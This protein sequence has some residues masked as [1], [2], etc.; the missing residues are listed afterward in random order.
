MSKCSANAQ[1][2]AG[3]NTQKVKAAREPVSRKDV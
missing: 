2:N 3:V 1:A